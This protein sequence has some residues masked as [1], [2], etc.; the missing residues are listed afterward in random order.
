MVWQQKK[1][2]KL[3]SARP[4]SNPALPLH[5]RDQLF[6]G[7][8]ASPPQFNVATAGA[9]GLF[10]PPGLEGSSSSVRSSRALD[11]NKAREIDKQLQHSALPPRVPQ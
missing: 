10:G 9:S 1:Q 4:E 2:R 11:I 7:E 5:T 8:F 6:Q 3:E